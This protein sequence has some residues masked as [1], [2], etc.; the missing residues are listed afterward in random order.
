MTV[1]FFWCSAPVSCRKLL[2]VQCG[3]LLRDSETACLT[4]ISLPLCIRFHRRYPFRHCDFPNRIMTRSDR[5]PPHSFLRHLL[6]LNEH[7]TRMMSF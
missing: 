4:S 7:S 6:W 2:P 5:H 1:I 3:V